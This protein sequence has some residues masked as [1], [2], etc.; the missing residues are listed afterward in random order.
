VKRERECVIQR[1]I[2]RR[3]EEEERVN[4]RRFFL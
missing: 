1:E 2:E 4:G 3:A